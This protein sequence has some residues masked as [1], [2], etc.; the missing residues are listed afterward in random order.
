M[1]HEPRI[2][3]SLRTASGKTIR[4][5]ARSRAAWFALQAT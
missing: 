3:T 2:S 4:N 1:L 5:V